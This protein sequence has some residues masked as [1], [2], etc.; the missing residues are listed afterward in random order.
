MDSY[1]VLKIG[2]ANNNIICVCIIYMSVCM[3]VCKCMC[4]LVC[5]YVCICIP[6]GVCFRAV[7]ANSLCIEFQ[8]A[9][10]RVMDPCIRMNS[11]LSAGIRVLRKC[12]HFL[13]RL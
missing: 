12:Q 8:E 1:I 7:H 9:R 3:H 2:G 5:K 13:T 10:V 11:M 6:I 4:I